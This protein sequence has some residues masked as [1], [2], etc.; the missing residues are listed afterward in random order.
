[1][2]KEKVE[3]KVQEKEVEDRESRKGEQSVGRRE[4]RQP[5]RRMTLG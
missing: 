2:E 4:N 1:M 3:V 5:L